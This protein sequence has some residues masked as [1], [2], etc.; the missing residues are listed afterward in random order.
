M[1]IFIGYA[2]NDTGVVEQL[3][4]DLVLAGHQVWFDRDLHRGQPWWDRIIDQ[5]RSCDM[6]V[7]VLSAESVSSPACLAEVGYAIVLNRHLL[8]VRAGDVDERL[9]P[10]PIPR[11][12]ILDYRSRGA[13]IAIQLVSAV[14][15]VAERPVAPDPEPAPPGAP[16]VSIEPIRAR[17]TQPNLSYGEQL[18]VVR[19]LREHLG[20]PDE[21]DVALG[22]LLQFRARPTLPSPSPATSM[23][24][25]PACWPT[26][27]SEGRPQADRDGSAKDLLL[28]LVTH[29]R[30]AHF[31]P[32][33]GW[34]LTDSLIAPRRLL[35]ADG[36]RPSS[37]RWQRTSRR[38]FPRS[39]GSSPS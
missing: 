14:A 39:P 1:Q 19:D 38:I 9:A 8:P 4:D 15:S 25:W 22:L 35:V 6:F 24:W 34:G 5:I 26:G 23:V 13:E 3:H 21:A 28:S 36:P 31:T 17:L 10:D 32:I 33:L 37:S 27:S 12:Q 29:I 18:D 7:F 11:L 30:R 16:I 2:R 20:Q